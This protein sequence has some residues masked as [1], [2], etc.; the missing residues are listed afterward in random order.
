MSTR[1]VGDNRRLFGSV[2][3]ESLLALTCRNIN[4][5]VNNP[6]LVK[7]LWPPNFQPWN[8]VGR[9]PTEIFLSQPDGAHAVIRYS[10]NHYAPYTL[11][12]W[13]RSEGLVSTYE[14]RFLGGN[15]FFS[16]NGQRFAFTTRFDDNN[17][18]V[19]NVFDFESK[20]RRRIDLPESIH[21]FRMDF[22]D[23]ERLV[24][25]ERRGYLHTLDLATG[26][27]S[28]LLDPQ[29]HHEAGNVVVAAHSD[30]TKEWVAYT[31]EEPNEG[32]ENYIL[33]YD[34]RNEKWVRRSI[35]E[36]DVEHMAFSPTGDSLLLVGLL[37]NVI[38]YF[39][40]RNAQAVDDIGQMVAL[41]IQPTLTPPG[42]AFQHYCMTRFSSFL[43][44]GTVAMLSL[45]KRELVICDI[46]LEEQKVFPRTFSSWKQLV[47]KDFAVDDLK[48][49][50]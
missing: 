9:A 34:L 20:T 18:T 44:D 38:C 27:I 43:P 8:R 2:G 33:F 28:G 6:K 16:P 36:S 37:R 1:H 30:E 32:E 22:L 4:K 41:A 24:F 31:L 49:R 25:T 14:S 19:V 42:E 12:I 21:I 50:R 29:P 3:F 15:H 7:K 5:I 46:N 40:L 13:D 26:G 39:D 10:G 35:G 48:K 23:N 11:T 47:D 17:R 45:Q